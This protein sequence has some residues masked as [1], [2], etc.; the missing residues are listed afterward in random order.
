MIAVVWPIEDGCVQVL[1]YHPAADRHAFSE[2]ALR[3][4]NCYVTK[5]PGGTEVGALL[6]RADAAPLT[7]I[8]EG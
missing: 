8:G 1:S 6:P 3:R 2:A 5:V 4:G 7:Q